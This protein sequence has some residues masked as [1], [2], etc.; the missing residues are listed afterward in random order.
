M[1]VRWN[2]NTQMGEKIQLRHACGNVGEHAGNVPL[3]LNFNA[4]N[5]APQW[6]AVFDDQFTTVATNVDDMPNFHADKW[7]KMFGTGT[8]NSKL[9]NKV[10]ESTLQPVQP[11][12]RNIKDDSIDEE[13]AL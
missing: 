12:S 8:H 11:V 4:G 7:S 2:V 13:E 10:K 3:V 1:S 5:I 9:D 6:N